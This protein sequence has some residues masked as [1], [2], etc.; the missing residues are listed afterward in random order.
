MKSRWAIG[1]VLLV[2]ACGPSGESCDRCT[3]SQHLAELASRGA[4]TCGT[5]PIEGPSPRLVSCV[6]AHLDAGLPFVATREY[7]GIDST[8]ETGWVS[9]GIRTTALFF[10]SN[11]CGGGDCASPCG[12]WLV[13]ERCH[14]PVSDPVD[15]I[16]CSRWSHTETLCDP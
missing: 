5:A 10:D 8:L 4:N 14:D 13:S 1:S 11:V 16:A 7:A 15:L 12:P 2:A 9:D 6:Q 3:L